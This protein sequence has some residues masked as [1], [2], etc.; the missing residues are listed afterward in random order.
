M[1]ASGLPRLA[2]LAAV[3]RV[4]EDLDGAFAD[5]ERAEA[6]AERTTCVEQRARIHFLR[7]NLYFPA[8]RHRGLP[9]RASRRVCELARQIGSPELEAPALGGLGDAEYV[10]GR[11]LSAHR[12]FERCVELAARTASAGSRS[13]TAPM[14]RS[15]DAVLRTAR[16]RPS[17]DALAATPRA[18]DGRSSARRD[19][20]PP[21]PH[22][23]LR[24]RS[25]NLAG[26]GR[27]S[28]RRLT[29]ARQLGARRFLQ[30]CCSTSGRAALCGGPSADAEAARSARPCR[31]AARP[32]W[33]FTVPTILERSPRAC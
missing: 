10:R 3:K 18:A 33:H 28:T 2:R 22:F 4:T 5:L 29:L 11:M 15:R 21:T 6:A 23:S 30:S 20:W 32:A 17:S 9:R 12:H 24:R 7:G 26:C 14:A 1:T 16:P 27:R 31:S 13:P 19:Q 8:R 25:A